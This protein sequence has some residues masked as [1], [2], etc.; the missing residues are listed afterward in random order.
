MK[1]TLRPHERFR[2]RKDFLRIYRKGSRY[3]GKGFVLIYLSN[4]LQFSRMAVVASKK[5]GNA[6]VRNRIKR[7]FRALFRT[8]KDLLQGSFDLVVITET[9]IGKIAWGEVQKEFI[10]AIKFL[11]LN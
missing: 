8:N 9:R 10:K 4:K 1:E 2:K 6:V 7:R 5:I 11:P 3:R